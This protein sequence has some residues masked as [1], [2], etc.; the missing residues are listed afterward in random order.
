MFTRKFFM[1]LSVLALL[2]L[3]ACASAGVSVDLTPTAP[4]VPTS[5]SVSKQSNIE[6][7][8]GIP[9]Y[10]AGPYLYLT[11]LLGQDGQQ[12]QVVL[13]QNEAVDWPDSCLGVNIQGF[14]CS[15]VVTAGY[16]LVFSTPKGDFEFHTN[17]NGD[18]YQLASEPQNAAQELP[19]LAWER[20]GGFAG[21]CQRLL[22]TA[23][24]Q[25]TITDCRR[26]QVL[27]QG[28][29]TDKQQQY[30]HDL[31]QQYGTIAWKTQPPYNPD[32]FIDQFALRGQGGDTPVQEDLTA[33][34][35]YLGGMVTE[36]MAAPA[37]AAIDIGTG[38]EGQVVLSPG[39]GGPVKEGGQ[40]C[41]DKPYQTTL[42][43]KDESGNIVSQA[44]SDANGN[45]KVSLAPGTYVLRPETA[46]KFPIATDTTVTVTQGKL[47]QVTIK[48]DSGM[49]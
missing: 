41:P 10:A 23:S 5:I 12:Q 6:L 43:V 40:G 14:M 18:A 32:Q 42:Q 11:T 27:K 1:I 38:I 15:Q 30:I 17:K 29:L 25:Y 22:V 33:I 8:A 2:I 9:Q 26:N 13:K 3:S 16:K 45:F 20:S 4:V 21:I 39:C 37:S 35:Q 28:T 24:N 36:N 49:R 47:T 31:L 44:E 34:D 7:P 19:V 48:L 46:G